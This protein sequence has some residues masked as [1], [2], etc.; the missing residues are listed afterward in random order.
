MVSNR[1]H[2]DT[3]HRLPCARLLGRNLYYWMPDHRPY[4]GIRHCLATG[5]HS[6][7]VH[8]DML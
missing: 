5:H 8:V 1:V 2:L 6:P 7:A 4:V 3:P